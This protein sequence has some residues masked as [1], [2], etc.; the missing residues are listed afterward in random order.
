MTLSGAQVGRLKKVS[1]DGPGEPSED[2]GLN[3]GMIIVFVSKNS[4]QKK[5]RP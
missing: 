5:G 4:A 1:A 3:D 2:S